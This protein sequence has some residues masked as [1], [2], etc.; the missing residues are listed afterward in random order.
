MDAHVPVKVARLGEP[1]E[2]EMGEHLQAKSRVF[3]VIILTST[4]TA[5]TGK[6]FP[7]CESSDASSA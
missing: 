6:V 5:Y 1:M 7:R 3:L 4:D 2:M